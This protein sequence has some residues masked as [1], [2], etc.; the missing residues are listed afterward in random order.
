MLSW[1]GVGCQTDKN[2]KKKEKD[3]ATF[4]KEHRSATLLF[5]CFT[6][7]AEL[8]NVKVKKGEKESQAAKVGA[9]MRLMFFDRARATVAA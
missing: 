8:E 3:S 1:F 9:V 7:K 6:V 5:V 2:E 4:C